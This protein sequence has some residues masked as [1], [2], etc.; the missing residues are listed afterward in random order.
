MQWPAPRAKALFRSMRDRPSQNFAHAISMANF[1]QFVLRTAH[2][3]ISA[4]WLYS[5]GRHRL[6]SLSNAD[7]VEFPTKHIRH[8]S[9]TNDRFSINM[10]EFVDGE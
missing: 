6:L 7:S 2:P 8:I 5:P 10:S 9:V 3:N 4:T 1:P